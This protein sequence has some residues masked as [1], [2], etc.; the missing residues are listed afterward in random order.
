MKGRRTAANDCGAITSSFIAPPAGCDASEALPGAVKPGA[1][2][3]ANPDALLATQTTRRHSTR[4]L[5]TAPQASHVCFVDMIVGRPAFS[6]HSDLNHLESNAHNAAVGQGV[7][8]G[9]PQK[10]KCFP[11]TLNDRF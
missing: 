4:F 7:P 11:Q 5:T 8:L 10:L 1:L 9:D 3:P 2:S 6:A